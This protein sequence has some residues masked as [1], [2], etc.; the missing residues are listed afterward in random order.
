MMN[1]FYKRIV[2]I[3]CVAALVVSAAGCSPVFWSG[4][5]R[6][7]MPV[8]DEYERQ[9]P[10]F[11]E[12]DEWDMGDFEY[13]YPEL[14]LTRTKYNELTKQME[15][16]RLVA[17]LPIQ[18]DGYEGSYSRDDVTGSR[19]GIEVRVRIL[20]DYDLRNRSDFS[21]GDNLEYLLEQEYM[22]EYASKRYRDV[23]ISDVTET[24]DR[25]SATVTMTMLNYDDE[26]VRYDVAAVLLHTEDLTTLATIG[27]DYGQL[28]GRYET[29]VSELEQFYGVDL[30]IEKNAAG[31]K[32]PAANTP[33]PAKQIPAEPDEMIS[34]ELPAGWE[35][36]GDGMYS[37]AQSV[38]GSADIFA[39]II[40]DDYGYGYDS[41]EAL[42]QECEQSDED[43]FSYALMDKP[44]GKTLMAQQEE[45][46]MVMIAYA[47]NLSDTQYA[48][49]TTYS[50]GTENVTE[51]FTAFA[52]HVL[53][54]GSW[55]PGATV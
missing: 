28:E 45:D 9:K 2:L 6:T 31:K 37:Y 42:V 30:N 16:K 38:Y 19:M 36:L 29:M 39:M 24:E 33:E 23:K 47:V 11:G 5:D 18:T 10:V 13:L 51:P 44:L 17:Y 35:D 50:G 54:T 1:K 4:R 26:Y 25:A 12:A 53:T 21:M 22:G 48:V 34:F 49:I 7:I 43:G 27:V 41:F 8:E 55:T 40:I 46:G 52:E 20:D 3:V 32:T 15:Y 14:L